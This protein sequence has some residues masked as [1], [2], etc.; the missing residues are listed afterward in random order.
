MMG[1]RETGE[2]R[3][4]MLS[5]NGGVRERERERALVENSVG[6]RVGG[7]CLE[8]GRDADKGVSL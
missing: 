2:G 7:G 8:S 1:K 6:G 5:V 3:G 4:A